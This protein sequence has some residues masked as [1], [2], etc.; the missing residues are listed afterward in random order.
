MRH[1]FLLSVIL[2]ILINGTYIEVKAQDMDPTVTI[3]VS[4]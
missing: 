3:A 4:G 2:L 1:A